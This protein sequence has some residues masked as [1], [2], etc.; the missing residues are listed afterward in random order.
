VLEK[1]IVLDEW[2][3]EDN[4]RFSENADLYPV[5]VSNNFMGCPIT[6]GALG[7]DSYV[8]VTENYTQNDGSTS[9]KLTGLS[10]EVLTFVCDKI[11]LT[12][13]SFHQCQI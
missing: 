3:F 10:I 2:V 9:Y 1:A 5:K 6:V 13:V 8:I 11:K 12:A 7:I 4:D